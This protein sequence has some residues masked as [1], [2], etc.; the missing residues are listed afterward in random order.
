MRPWSAEQLLSQLLETRNT[1][2]VEAPRYRAIEVKTV[3]QA[4]RTELAKCIQT[5]PN[6]SVNLMGSYET[7]EKCCK[8]VCD[9]IQDNTVVALITGSLNYLMRDWRPDDTL[10]ASLKDVDVKVFYVSNESRRSSFLVESKLPGTLVDVDL[11]MCPIHA[12]EDFSQHV[13][14][15]LLPVYC[16]SRKLYKVNSSDDCI[17][18]IESFKEWAHNLHL[19][20]ALIPGVK[21][22]VLSLLAIHDWD[23]NNQNTNQDNKSTLVATLGEI[24]FRRNEAN[25]DFTFE[26]NFLEATQCSYADAYKMTVTD[27]GRVRTRRLGSAVLRRGIS[28]FLL[29]PDLEWSEPPT[30]LVFASNES[31]QS[32]LRRVTLYLQ[33]NCTN[34][35]VR[36]VRVQRNDEGVIVDCRTAP[37]GRE[38][39][40]DHQPH[41]YDIGL[42]WKVTQVDKVPDDVLGT[43]ASDGYDYPAFHP[44]AADVYNFCEKLLHRYDSSLSLIML[45]TSVVVQSEGDLSLI[46]YHTLDSLPPQ[47][48]FYY[49]DRKNKIWK[50]ED[51]EQDM[52]KDHLLSW[53]QENLNS[54]HSSYKARHKELLKRINHNFIRARDSHGESPFIY[55]ATS[56][57]L[58]LVLPEWCSNDDLQT[59]WKS[60]GPTKD[61]SWAAGTM[62]KNWKSWIRRYEA[63]LSE[64]LKKATNSSAFSTTPPASTRTRF[65]T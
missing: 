13:R 48:M 65:V 53:F 62:R 25:T 52:V 28:T 6:I 61:G 63:T 42:A 10:P 23:S 32:I 49:K 14:W 47:N 33:E 19:K 9:N 64:H 58:K 31:T 1:I 4:I 44:V 15:E 30:R 41:Q 3:I 57:R 51:E 45:R 24:V 35:A 37:L 38:T 26:I 5:V 39:A 43:H 22:F 2:P 8:S 7:F 16:V 29:T 50:L 46:Y 56:R 27:I 54:N 21:G 40:V 55:N 20:N 12:T 60:V 36:V 18:H 11:N 17:R 34:E 59:L